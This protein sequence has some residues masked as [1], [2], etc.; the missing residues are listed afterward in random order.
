MPQNA[1][2]PHLI[3]CPIK[4]GTLSGTDLKFFLSRRGNL[5]RL[6]FCKSFEIVIVLD[7]FLRVFIFKMS[8]LVSCKP[9]VSPP[10]LEKCFNLGQRKKWFSVVLWVACGAI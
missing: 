3:T 1:F 7:F 10:N 2:R 9:L 4:C 5:T 8:F 6:K